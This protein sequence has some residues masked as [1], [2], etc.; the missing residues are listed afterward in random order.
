MS[1]F[2]WLWRLTGGRPM[3][4]RESLFTDKVSG[5]TVFHYEDRLGRHWMADMSW[6]L[7]RVERSP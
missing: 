1:G 3:I 6:S 2:T 7:F 4:R 5:L